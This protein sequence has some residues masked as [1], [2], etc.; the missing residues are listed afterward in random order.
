MSISKNK[1]KFIY[2]LC[3]AILGVFLGISIIFFMKMAVSGEGVQY[4]INE[5]GNT[6][7][8]G[9]DA[10]SYEEM[11][12]LIRAMGT[13]GKEGYVYFKDL[14]GFIPNNPEEAVAYMI[15]L[16]KTGFPSRFIP[17]YT[18]DGKTVIGE[19]EIATITGE[20]KE[21]LLKERNIP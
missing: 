18:Q 9:A 11:P 12:D 8:S 19:Y 5:N 7:G 13:N 15:E 10:P 14:Q 2:M 21:K 1:T 20:A 16:E 3:S 4:L 17:L 6:Y